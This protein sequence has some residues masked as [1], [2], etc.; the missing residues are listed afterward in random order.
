MLFC[1]FVPDARVGIS[2]EELRRYAELEGR[3]QAAVSDGGMSCLTSFA[4]DTI[5]IRPSFD[6]LRPKNVRAVQQELHET[7]GQI[8]PPKQQ[9][10]HEAAGQSNASSRSCMKLPV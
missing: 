10:L 5:A 4:N 1:H 9:E 2:A 3:I 8:E 6:D 7:A